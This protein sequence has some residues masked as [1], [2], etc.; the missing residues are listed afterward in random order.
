MR[1][2][3]IAFSPLMMAACLIPAAPGLAQE[4]TPSPS[5]APSM[6]GQ[7]TRMDRQ[8]DGRLHGLVAPYA[9]LPSVTTSLQYKVPTLTQ[10][11]GA[12]LTTQTSVQVGPANYLTKINLASMLAVQAR[13]G[14]VSFFGDYIYI[15]ASTS[16]SLTTSISGPKGKIVIPVSFDTTSRLAAGMW[17]FDAG[18]SLGHGHNADINAFAGLREFP[19]D[20][21]LN[22]NAVIGKRG[23]I[24][25]SGSLNFRPIVTDAIFGLR[26]SAYFGDDHWNVPYY[27]DY[28][29]GP[30]NQSWQGYTGAGYVFDH[31]Q[32]LLLIYRTLNYNSFTPASNVQHYVMAGPL[33]G[34]TIP[35]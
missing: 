27:V 29:V 22:Y 4:A 12:P 24:A 31:G 30:D 7:P 5:P 19:I 28:G 34:Y 8:Y 20:L 17:E 33:L 11:P 2:P 35:L 14:E 32:S 10:K 18:Y 21:T 13:Q 16:S 6:S 3:P 25:P 15:N 9:W 1:L 26:G 23:I